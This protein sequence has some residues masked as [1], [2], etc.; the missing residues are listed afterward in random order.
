MHDIGENVRLQLKYMPELLEKYS[1]YQTEPDNSDAASPVKRYRLV[2]CNDYINVM[3]EL[4]VTEITMADEEILSSGSV[5][6]LELLYSPA[7]KGLDSDGDMPVFYTDSAFCLNNQPFVLYA[8]G[9]YLS[10]HSVSSAAVVYYLRDPEIIE[11]SKLRR[12]KGTQFHLDSP[13][14]LRDH[15]LDTGE[16]CLELP[17]QKGSA[18]RVN[19][20]LAEWNGSTFLL[21]DNLASKIRNTNK[22]GYSSV[23]L[24]VTLD[25]FE[26]L[27]FQNLANEQ[28]GD[29]DVVFVKNLIAVDEYFSERD[30]LEEF[31]KRQTAEY[32]RKLDTHDVLDF[33]TACME[34]AGFA[35]TQ[36]K[37]RIISLQERIYKKW[38]SNMCLK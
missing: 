12:Y 8:S 15:L 16:Y 34:Y 18:P 1:S 21:R 10:S 22:S 31:L 7:D 30:L 33:Q 11:R 5:N 20:M 13:G 24:Q 2:L 38:N 19:E 3:R 14:L 4:G 28:S 35:E 23:L 37:K 27:L 6:C 29:V 9:S 26:K 25:A 32:S 17:A 36:I